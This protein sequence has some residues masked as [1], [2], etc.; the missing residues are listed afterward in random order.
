MYIKR[1]QVWILNVLCKIESFLM[2][3]IKSDKLEQLDHIEL[4]KYIGLD[5]ID[6]I[7]YLSINGNNADPDEDSE[8]SENNLSRYTA[9]NNMNDFLNNIGNEYLLLI[10]QKHGISQESMAESDELSIQY[11]SIFTNII[12][13]YLILRTTNI[14]KKRLFMDDFINELAHIINDMIYFD[15]FDNKNDLISNMYNIHNDWRCLN[16][17]PNMMIKMYESNIHL[18]D[19]ITMIRCGC[20]YDYSKLSILPIEIIDI[21]LLYLLEIS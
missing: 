8:Y 9:T 6:P 19:K 21:V 3:D 13:K 12:E 7:E 2:D 15:I 1:T 20:K 11:L 14:I 4:L 18:F 17:Y 16:F 5:K 10:K